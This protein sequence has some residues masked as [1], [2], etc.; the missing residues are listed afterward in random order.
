[1]GAK[2]DQKSI[3]KRKQ[4][5][6]RVEHRFL[7]DF[8]GFWRPSWKSKIDSK[9]HRKNYGKMKGTKMA[10]K[11]QQDVLRSGDPRGPEP[12]VFP[13]LRKG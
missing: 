1:M 8:G 11:S 10:K 5:G 9:R 3:K 13:N 7:I 4:K 2:I 6:N 12:W